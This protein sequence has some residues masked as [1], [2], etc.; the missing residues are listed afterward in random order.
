M[1]AKPGIP[2]SLWLTAGFAAGLGFGWLAF[3]SEPRKTYVAP[4][5]EVKAEPVTRDAGTLGA[6]ETQFERWGG[7]AV[8]ADDTTE[9]AFWDPRRKKHSDFYEV[10][11]I[12]GRFYYRTI[13]ALTRP[14]IDHGPRAAIPF[15]FTETQEMRERF[16]RENPDYDPSAEPRVDLPPKAPA[17]YAPRFER[18]PKVSSPLESTPTSPSTRPPALTPG[19]GG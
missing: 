5:L 13:P 8:W 7:Y 12:G 10:R 6:L 19:A 18:I 14:L 15:Q 4:P 17:R 9:F 16:Y 3:H 2:P 1:S 11:R